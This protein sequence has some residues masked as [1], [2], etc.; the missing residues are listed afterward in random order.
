MWASQSYQSS[1]NRFRAFI[2][3]APVYMEISVSLKPR[4]PLPTMLLL[5]IFEMFSSVVILFLK[6]S[7]SG[8]RSIG[9][10]SILTLLNIFAVCLLPLKLVQRRIIFES[11][12]IYSP[13]Y[14]HS[15]CSIENYGIEIWWAN[16]LVLMW[17]LE[18]N[19]RDPNTIHWRLFQYAI[20][21]NGFK[22]S[23]STTRLVELAVK[24][25]KSNEFDLI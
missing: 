17:K 13:Y 18:V 14:Y 15:I 21:W 11:F 24:R 22:M 12:S 9:F 6:F 4:L 23:P 25:D 16:I 7:S 19:F 10:K 3:G 8:Q 1:L 5:L 2:L 20:T